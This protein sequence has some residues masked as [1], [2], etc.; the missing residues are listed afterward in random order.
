LNAHA[1]SAA[2]KRIFASQ[3]NLTKPLDAAVKSG[4]LNLRGYDRC[5]RVALSIADLADREVQQQ[6]IAAAMVL[7][8]ED[9]LGVA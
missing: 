8:G 5:L 3:T 1:P 6:D 9:N 2:L 7:R 4:R